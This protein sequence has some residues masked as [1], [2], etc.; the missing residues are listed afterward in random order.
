MRCRR[1]VYLSRHCFLQLEQMWRREPA[2][3]VTSVQSCISGRSPACLARLRER[4]Q[5]TGRRAPFDDNLGVSGDD[6]V[7]R[8][9]LVGRSV[10]NV[11]I[12][13]QALSDWIIRQP[14]RDGG[15]SIREQRQFIL[16]EETRHKG[17]NTE[18][19]LTLLLVH[20][21]PFNVKARDAKT[22][23]LDGLKRLC[24]FE[25]VID[26]RHIVYSVQ[27]SGCQTVKV[28][29]YGMSKYPYIGCQLYACLDECSIDFFFTWHLT[30]VEDVG[31]GRRRQPRQPLLLDRM[32][33]LSKGKRVFLRD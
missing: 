7:I 14:S 16:D 9:F 12:K 26:N 4:K 24:R 27:L 18:E 1:R 22:I 3:F 6:C 21:F 17:L 23:E 30:A 28:F 25:F 32:V 15:E 11:Q 2:C 13:I 19:L 29:V 20:D 8:E 31:N 33:S 10:E 5:D